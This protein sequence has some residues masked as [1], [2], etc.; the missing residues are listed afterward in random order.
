[1]A[2]HNR[3]RVL[4]V[5]FICK[6]LLAP[7]VIGSA[8]YYLAS[9]FGFAYKPFLVLCGIVVGWPVKFSL[10]VRYGDWYRRRRA[11]A[12]GAV[13]APGSRWELSNDMSVLRDMQEANKNGFIGELIRSGRTP[14]IVLSNTALSI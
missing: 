14:R 9:R 13:T 3:R 2:S 1:M 6:T 4:A 7:T 8:V 10:G 5:R 12:L 11:M